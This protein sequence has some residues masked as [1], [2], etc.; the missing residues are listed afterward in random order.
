[1]KINADHFLDIDSTSTVLFAATARTEGPQLSR[2]R[3]TLTTASNKSLAA[4]S[5]YRALNIRSSIASVS[6]QM[7]EYADSANG[8]MSYQV[9]S[10]SNAKKIM[11]SPSRFLSSGSRAL[12]IRPAGLSPGMSIASEPHKIH[13]DRSAVVHEMFTTKMA[14]TSG[15]DKRDLVYSNSSLEVRVGGFCMAHTEP[16]SNSGITSKLGFGG[17]KIWDRCG[18]VWLDK[19][20]VLCN[21]RRESVHSNICQ[22]AVPSVH[23]DFR[24]KTCHP[25]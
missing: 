17:N 4:G 13:Q 22:A 18:I 20:R 25:V 10:K 19:G 11:P 8:T 3:L 24:Q 6:K 12:R 21:V 9:M 23:H 2:Q 14:K 7:V 16:S 1:L 15:A 5:N